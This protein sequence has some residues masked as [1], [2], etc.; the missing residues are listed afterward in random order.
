MGVV[1]NM[2]TWL[3]LD[4]ANRLELNNLQRFGDRVF[5][6]LQG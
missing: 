2:I 5:P 3:I 1:I 4:A 6:R